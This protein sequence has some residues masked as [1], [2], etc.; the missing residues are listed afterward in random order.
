[1][2]RVI[3]LLGETTAR[4]KLTFSIARRKGYRHNVP[5]VVVST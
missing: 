1:M 4:Q 5:V 3:S 2:L